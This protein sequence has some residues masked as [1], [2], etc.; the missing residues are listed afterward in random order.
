M[1]AAEADDA[2]DEDGIVFETPYADARLL[3]SWVLGLGERARLSGH[4]SWSTT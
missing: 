1:P 2:P 4:P 3:V